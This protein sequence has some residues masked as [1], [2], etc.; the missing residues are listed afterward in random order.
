M[1]GDGGYINGPEIWLQWNNLTG[2]T[3]TPNTAQ[4][5]HCNGTTT[6][7]TIASEIVMWGS[8]KTFTVDNAGAPLTISGVIFQYGGS[9]GIT[10]TGAGTLVLT[11]VNTY[12]G[13]TT[14]TPARYNWAT[15]PPT[16]PSLETS[17]ITPPWSSI[18]AFPQVRRIAA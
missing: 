12:D 2:T 11:G 4:G 18:T 14:V 17:P 8:S 5:I 10:K 9:Y 13:P 16:A 1:I 7:A 15:G 3:P 6:G